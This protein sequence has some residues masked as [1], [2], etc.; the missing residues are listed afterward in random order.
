MPEEGKK[1]D[2]AIKIAPSALALAAFSQLEEQKKE[3][4]LELPSFYES[5][6]SQNNVLI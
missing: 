1:D 6:P 3:T 4:E 2:K 5:N